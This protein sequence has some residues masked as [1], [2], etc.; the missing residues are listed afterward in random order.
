M[1]VELELDLMTI[2]T[3]SVGVVP[4]TIFVASN[5][6]RVPPLHTSSNIVII[7]I[8]DIYN[9]MQ[10]KMKP[11]CIAQGTNRRLNI[12]LGIIFTFYY[13]VSFC[14]LMKKKIINLLQ[15]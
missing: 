5:V 13:Y 11:L 14:L 6:N 15:C 7:I 4:D 2:R 12:N 8:V 3:M 10:Y 1:S 9:T